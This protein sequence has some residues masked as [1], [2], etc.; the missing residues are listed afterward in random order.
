MSLTAA[1]ESKHI[2]RRCQSCRRRKA[3]FQYRGL[4]RADRDHTLCFECYRALRDQRR[5][6]GLTEQRSA[7]VPRSPFSRPLTARQAMHRRAL[8]S[9]L[10][11]MA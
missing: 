8:L 1:R 11:R 3:R 5:A 2:R 7:M 6:Q 4:V 9:H 10:E